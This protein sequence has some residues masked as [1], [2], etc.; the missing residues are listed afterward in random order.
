[1]KLFASGCY[2]D[3]SFETTPP[4]TL[5]QRFA[6]HSIAKSAARAMAIMLH[7]DRVTVSDGGNT[8]IEFVSAKRVTPKLS[9]VARRRQRIKKVMRSK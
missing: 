8:S 3:L 1:M 6:N 4:L 9:D 5:Q 7:L 2:V